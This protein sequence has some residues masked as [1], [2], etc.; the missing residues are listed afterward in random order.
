MLV[1]SSSSPPSQNSLISKHFID[2]L[3]WSEVE[4]GVRKVDVVAYGYSKGFVSAAVCI[5]KNHPLGRLNDG[6][7][8]ICFELN[9]GI[10]L[11]HVYLKIDSTTVQRKRPCNIDT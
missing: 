7:Y 3:L 6:A 10:V 4:D 5:A 2:M 11:Y 1:D 9:K 8:H